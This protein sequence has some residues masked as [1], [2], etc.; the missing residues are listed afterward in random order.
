MKR[1]FEL[2]GR[3]LRRMATLERVGSIL[4]IVA[5]PV[6]IAGLLAGLPLD[7]GF[8]AIGPGLV[9]YSKALEE[10]AS[11]VRFGNFQN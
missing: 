4:T 10:R 7:F 9:A 3:D 6:A 1:D 8:T 5:L 2:A 11:W